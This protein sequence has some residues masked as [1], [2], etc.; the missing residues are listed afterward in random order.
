MEDPEGLETR[1]PAFKKKKKK[2]K[3]I[4]PG[5]NFTHSLD[6][7]G[8]MMGYQNS[9]FPVAI[10]GSIDTYS[11]RIMW[12]K[13]WT[14]NSDPIYPAKWFVECLKKNKIMPQYLRMDKGTETVK[15][16]A[17]QCY[18][19]GETFNLTPEEASES[20]VYG[21]STSN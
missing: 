9:T 3:F 2:G 8:K 14:T 20:V 19:K 18:I 16:A 13:V 4:S 5:P 11:R 15:L 1:C 17:I 6:V 10:Y 21:P 7:H 12:I